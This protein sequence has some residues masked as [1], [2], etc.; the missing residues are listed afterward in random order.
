MSSL[1]FIGGEKGGV[2][3]SVAARVLAQYFID[4]EKLAKMK[5]GAFLINVSRARI[6]DRDALINGLHAHGHKAVTALISPKHLAAVI[7][8]IAKSG[9]IVVCLGA[10][11]ITA[12]A[13][14]LPADLA[15]IA[16]GKE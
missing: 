6:I 15:A 13:H 3:K 9:D 1:N 2:G 16:K 7:D 12:W 4:R 8:D 5:R 14:A 11:N 10:G